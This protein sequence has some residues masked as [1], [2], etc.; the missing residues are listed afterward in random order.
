M[1]GVVGLIQSEERQTVKNILKNKIKKSYLQRTKQ[2]A[3]QEHKSNN[4][5]ERHIRL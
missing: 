1:H 4:V 5:P 3:F 2:Y